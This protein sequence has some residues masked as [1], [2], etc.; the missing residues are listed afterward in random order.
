LADLR[1]AEREFG[2]DFGP[3]GAPQ[4]AFK[5][6]TFEVEKNPFRIRNVSVVQD[7]G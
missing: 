7:G 5:G 4:K 2:F 3:D 1:N 6:M